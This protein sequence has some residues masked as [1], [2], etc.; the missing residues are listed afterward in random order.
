MRESSD[1][2]FTP[3]EGSEHVCFAHRKV[4]DHVATV[5]SFGSSTHVKSPT[6]E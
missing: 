6:P 1:T 5:G 2:V 3:D 4:D